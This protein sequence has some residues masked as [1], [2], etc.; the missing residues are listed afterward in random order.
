MSVVAAP[1]SPFSR[2]ARA[3]RGWSGSVRDGVSAVGDFVLFSAKALAAVI[4]ELLLRRRFYKEVARQISDVVAG[5]GAFVVGGGMVFVVGAMSLAT[6]GTLGI[7]AY[8]GLRTIGAESLTGIVTSLGNVREITP[9]IAGIALAAQVGSSFTAELGAKRISEEIDALSVMSIPPV[10]YLVSTRILA[11]L[12]AIVPLYLVSLF[13][14]FAAS[15]LVT[16][17]LLGLSQGVYDYY[18]N[19]FLPPVDLLYSLIKAS[20]FAVLVVLIHCWYGYNATGGPAGVGMAVGRAIRTS[21]MTIV[22]VNLLLS[23]LFWGTTT[24]ASL[25]G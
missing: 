24:T 4:T 21:M 10:A 3:L 13:A 7:Q 9:M 6:G 1:S 8:E 16:V 12:I 18:F 20:V 2:T 23:F 25:T 5:A 17:R 11:A 15:E 22:V 14:S 19:L